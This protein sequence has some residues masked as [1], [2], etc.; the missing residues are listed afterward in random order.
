MKK[1]VILV[2]IFAISFF[3]GAADNKK[4]IFEQLES[5]KASQQ[6]GFYY[7]ESFTALC[8]DWQNVDLM[9]FVGDAYDL[10]G[11]VYRAQNIL[12]RALKIDPNNK[13]IKD[14]LKQVNER[15]NKIETKIKTLEQGPHEVK[16]FVQLATIYLGL[17]DLTNTRK[18]LSKA[19]SLDKNR[20]NIIHNLIYGGFVR[21][22]QIPTKKSIQL[23]SEALSEYKKGNKEKA[24]KL[25]KDALALSIVSPFVYDNL[26]TMLLGEK[27]Y[28]GAIRA[29]EE[30][31]AIVKNAALAID[32]GNLYFVE[33]D[34]TQAF[35]YF[36]EA[37]Q[38]HGQSAEAYYNMALCM[39]ILGDKEGAKQF[40][41]TAYSL[42]PA[43][44]NKKGKSVVM[45]KGMEIRL[46]SSK[47]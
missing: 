28:G 32:L 13:K 36:Q 37:T 14:K 31:F 21:E 44:K 43:L 8:N 42:N 18:Y 26:G 24:F 6:Y 1:S 15:I 34:Y 16:T 10:F 35:D 17:K 38:L 40:Y 3:A 7:S 23:S 33:G 29:F 39:D 4:D 22:L 2:L 5:L 47:K 11:N 12:E 46:N 41:Q 45:V 9:Y 27:N 20:T 25:M 19:D 30:E